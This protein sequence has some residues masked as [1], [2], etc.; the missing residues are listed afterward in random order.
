MRIHLTT[1]SHVRIRQLPQNRHFSCFS[2]TELLTRNFSSRFSPNS[3]A[4]EGNNWTFFS[5]FSW[6]VYR[7]LTSYRPNHRIS[8]YVAMYKKK[9]LFQVENIFIDNRKIITQLLKFPRRNFNFHRTYNSHRKLYSAFSTQHTYHQ[10]IMYLYLNNK[11][12]FWGSLI[13]KFP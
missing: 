5:H 11:T 9:I 6:K 1:P 10:H 13:C 3:G 4:P 2:Q 12:N 8:S 7:K